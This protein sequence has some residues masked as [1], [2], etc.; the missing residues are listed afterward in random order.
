MI[1]IESL[2][3]GD[4]ILR[5]PYWTCMGSGLAETI[6]RCNLSIIDLEN[7]LVNVTDIKGAR[8][9]MQIAMRVIY[10]NMKQAHKKS[11]VSKPIL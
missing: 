6:G 11:N 1:M 9:A 10:R 4:C 5:S 3:Q 8:Y 7:T 2:P